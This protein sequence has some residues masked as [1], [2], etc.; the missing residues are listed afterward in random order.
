MTPQEQH[1]VAH[2]LFMESHS[3]HEWDEAGPF[4]K[5]YYN[6]MAKLIIRAV[7]IKRSKCGANSN[8][9]GIAKRETGSLTVHHL[10]HPEPGRS[11]HLSDHLHN[12]RLGS[13]VELIRA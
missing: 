8:V 9:A 11:H 6:K 10:D 3:A 2:A 13:A 7:D 4:E 1:A 5:A 12:R